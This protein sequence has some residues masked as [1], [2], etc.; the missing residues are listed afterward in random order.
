MTIDPKPRTILIAEDDADDRQWIRDALAE[1][2][3]GIHVDFVVDGEELM[4]FL[5]HRGKYVVTTNLA[6]PGMILLDLNMPKKDGRE[7]LKEIKSDPRIRH[8]PIVVLTTSRA[9]EDTFRT[10]NLGANSVIHKPVTID[11]LVQ[12]MLTLTDYWFKTVELPL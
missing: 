2:H 1:C 5:Q 7:C 10:Y 11:N 12:M 3:L 4:D 8:I 9:E 6:Y